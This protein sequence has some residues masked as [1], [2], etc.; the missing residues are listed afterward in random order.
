MMY[1][2]YRAVRE[3][4]RIKLVSIVSTMDSANMPSWTVDVTRVE[5]LNDSVKR[6]VADAIVVDVL[7]RFLE[8][9]A[10]ER[11]NLVLESKLSK[12][13][14][15]VRLYGIVLA[16]QDNLSIVSCGGLM[17]RVPMTIPVSDKVYIGITK[18]R[19]RRRE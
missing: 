17:C 8:F 9:E 19:R 12:V 2:A 10:N 16:S 5:K 6:V 1:R 7:T 18:S 15:V 13:K 11:I 4:N 3:H 14:G